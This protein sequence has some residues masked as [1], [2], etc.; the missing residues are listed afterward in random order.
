VKVDILKFVIPRLGHDLDVF[1]ITS[2]S[3]MNRL[4]GSMTRD[5]SILMGG[6]SI[7]MFLY[8]FRI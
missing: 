4:S 1:K 2:K 7:V 5:Y 8:I 6:D 3:G